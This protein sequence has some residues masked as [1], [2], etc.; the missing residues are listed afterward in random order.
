VLKYLRSG[1]KAGMVIPDAADP[2]IDS[3]R[4]MIE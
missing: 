2:S 4:V 1:I 3:V